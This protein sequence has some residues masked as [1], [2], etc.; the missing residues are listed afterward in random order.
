MTASTFLQSGLR[1]IKLEMEA[2]ADL[3]S[4]LDGLDHLDPPEPPDL[5]VLIV[6]G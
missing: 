5:L 1:T 3:E 6:G 4:R 2:I